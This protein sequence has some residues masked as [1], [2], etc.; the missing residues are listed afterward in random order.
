MPKN[1]EIH[2]SFWKSTYHLYGCYGGIFM[3]MLV[4]FGFSNLS[5]YAASF[6]GYILGRIFYWIQGHFAEESTKSVPIEN[7]TILIKQNIEPIKTIAPQDSVKVAR[8]LTAFDQF[9]IL[10]H[11]IQPLLTSEANEKIQEIHSLLTLLNHKLKSSKSVETQ[12]AI[13]NIQRIINN[14][15]TPTL[16]H[17]QE[18]PIIFHNRPLDDSNTPD[19]LIMQ[20]MNLVQDE[21]LKMTE[22]IFLDDLNALLAHGLFLEQKLKPTQ[23]FK[24]GSDLAPIRSHSDPTILN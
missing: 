6:G 15:L 23:F 4:V 5:W 10:K 21:L 17:Y 13:E 19:Q 11:Q 9:I 22:D 20:Q 16:T 1:P 8:P 14:Y 18:L 24:V 7:K 2:H 3:C 12:R